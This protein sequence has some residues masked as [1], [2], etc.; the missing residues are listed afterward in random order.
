[1]SHMCDTLQHTATHTAAHAETHTATHTATHCNTHCDT[2]CNTHCNTLQLLRGCLGQRV[3]T[4]YCKALWHTATHCDTHCNTL[5]QPLW[6]AYYP[7]TKERYDSYAAAYPDALIIHAQPGVRA[8]SDGR[9][10]GTATYPATHKY[11][12]ISTHFHT[13]P[14]RKFAVCHVNKC[15][16]TATHCNTQT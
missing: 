10:G 15:E 16:G 3:A 1:M 7:G 14:A 6:P 11:K 4:T 13:R 5:Q 12:H 2:R 9:C 8:K